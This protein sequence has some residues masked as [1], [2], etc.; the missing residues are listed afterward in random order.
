[1]FESYGRFER[2]ELT[3]TVT[4]KEYSVVI[5]TLDG[6]KT[7]EEYTLPAATLRGATE[8]VPVEWSYAVKCGDK[9]YPVTDGKFTPDKE[10]E[11]TVTYT[12]EYRGRTYT[13]EASLTV[14]KVV[15]SV[16]VPELEN[17]TS[18]SEYTLK[19][20]ELSDGLG[21]SVEGSGVVWSY[22]VA[23]SDQE[24]YNSLYGAI[25]VSNGVFT[26]M[27]AG[28]YT[29]T[30]T[31][32]FDG[33]TYF[34]TATLT[35]VR[36]AAEANEIESFDDYTSLDSVRLSDAQNLAHDYY[37]TYLSD[38]NLLPEGALGGVSFKRPDGVSGDA[39]QNAY[40]SST[41]M[42]IEKIKGYDVVVVPLWIDAGDV[43]SIQVDINGSRVF[44]ATKTWVKL[45]IPASYF[46]GRVSTTDSIFWI[47]NGGDGVVNQVTEV[48]IASVYAENTATSAPALL[49]MNTL[50]GFSFSDV[51]HNGA[52]LR[53]DGGLNAIP[54]EL[55]ASSNGSQYAMRFYFEGG[56]DCTF[57]MRTRATDQSTNPV[58][59]WLDAGYT[60]LDISF[61]AAPLSG[62]SV[63]EIQ[64][65]TIPGNNGNRASLSL[66]V[67]EWVTLRFGLEGL[68]EAFF[69]NG[70]DSAWQIELFYMNKSDAQLSE[71]WV[72]D[73]TVSAPS[74]IDVVSFE[75]ESTLSAFNTTENASLAWMD[76][77]QL[78]IVTPEDI[79]GV[80][81]LTPN[82][83]WNIKLSSKT[84]DKSLYKSYSAKMLIY[85]AS[86][87][88]TIDLKAVHDGKVTL[89]QI[90]TNSWVTIE[91]PA[92]QDGDQ[93]DLYDVFD[94]FDGLT[95]WLQGGTDVTAV[96]VAGVWL[97]SPTQA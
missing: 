31:A 84:V 38:K 71:V 62:N 75:S 13:A 76:A 68:K 69:W 29:V 28:E 90:Q 58:Q 34:Q 86:D 53:F 78:D 96:Y 48:R 36:A 80:V 41:R 47:Q 24:L 42:D 73:F 81:K 91:V 92:Y 61:Y 87:G 79:Q 32:D 65:Q 40:F 94:W 21:G 46:A 67:G 74:R 44:V 64:V 20:A 49:D 33:G 15:Y 72:T 19:E 35:V 59:A 27:I 1:M 37:E 93:N 52:S 57:S 9:T 43:A 77:N 45:Y 22:S 54:V 55:K 63:G 7:G 26:P 2:G 14:N 16:E 66:S 5:P 11:Y 3:V 88:D 12:A 83:N 18:G 82:G 25:I 51:W 4:E 56:N 85:L 10:G 95:G 17:G 39:W 23:F 6:G 50:G 8:G 70:G 30:Y 89:S 97:E 60:A